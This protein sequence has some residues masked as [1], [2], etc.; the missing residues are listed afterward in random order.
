[1]K[2]EMASMDKE[3]ERPQQSLWCCYYAIQQNQL[4]GF[5]DYFSS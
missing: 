5:D 4:T 2:M 3:N 1:M